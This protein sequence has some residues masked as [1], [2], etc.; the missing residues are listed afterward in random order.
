MIQND[1]KSQEPRVNI[2]IQV[3]IRE[4]ISEQKPRWKH[5]LTILHL[6]AFVIV[7]IIFLYYLF[8]WNTKGMFFTSLASIPL[9]GLLM[10]YHAPYPMYNCWD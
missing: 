7:G 6:L 10:C 3:E 4:E 8:A 9:F 5:V 2:D 1:L